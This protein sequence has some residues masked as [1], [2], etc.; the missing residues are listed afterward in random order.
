MFVNDYFLKHVNSN[1]LTILWR[2][3]RYEN[4][5]RDNPY[6]KYVYDNI[7]KF[8][9]YR[10]DNHNY[11][12]LE[13][14]DEYFLVYFYRQTYYDVFKIKTE[15]KFNNIERVTITD[16]LLSNMTRIGSFRITTKSGHKVRSFVMD[17]NMDTME[18]ILS[19]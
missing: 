4:L 3:E 15:H 10:T 2:L 1:G 5:T 12:F 7:D 19:E 8:K 16:V 18:I 6:F 14:N 17:K 11:L 9:T 13:Y